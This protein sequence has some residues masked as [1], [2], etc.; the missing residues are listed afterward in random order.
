MVL[1]SFKCYGHPNV[2]S[3]HKSTLEF[4]AESVLTLRGDCILGIKATTNLVNLPAEIKNIIREKE[5]RIKLTLNVNGLMEEIEG[6][7]HPDLLLSDET[8]IIIRK[9][10]FFCPRT[11]MIN[12]NKSAN[13]IS[14]EI[15]VIMRDTNSIMEITLQAESGMTD[16]SK[17]A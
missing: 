1:V 6:N 2:T 16:T 11:L 4:T 12:A 8:A 9:S 15:R 13:D 3:I 14:D 17:H 5:S 10:N 7:G